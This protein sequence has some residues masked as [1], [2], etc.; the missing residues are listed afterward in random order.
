MEKIIEE[1][2]IAHLNNLIN[3]LVDV[4]NWLQK[5]PKE[6]IQKKIERRIMSYNIQK[7]I[8]ERKQ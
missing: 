8:I 2:K 1:I 3:D 6:K 5:D 7:E 4:L